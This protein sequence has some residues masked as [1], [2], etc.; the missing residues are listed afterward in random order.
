MDVTTF[1]LK[2]ETTFFITDTGKS[3]KYINFPSDDTRRIFEILN[4]VVLIGTTC[5]FGIA[6]NLINIMV[7]CKQ[8]LDNTVNISLFGIAISDLA[9]LI[10]LGWLITCLNPFAEKADLPFVPN[11]IQYLS[12]G[13]PHLCFTRTTCCIT[14]YITVERC[15]CIALP[16]KVKQIITPARTK[17]IIIF[18]FILMILSLTPEYSTTYFGWKFNQDLNRTV[19][20]LLFTANREKVAG[21]VFLLHAVFGLFSF[22][23]VTGFTVALVLKLKQKSQWRKKSMCDTS[24]SDAISTRDKK[25]VAMVVV[26]AVVLIVCFIPTVTLHTVVFFEPKFSIVGQ[27]SN[28]FH[29][30]WSFAFLFEAVNSS[31][32]IFLYY[33]MS[34]NYRQTFNELFF[35]VRNVS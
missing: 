19:L 17:C 31:V 23:I 12:G 14:L 20:G 11:E 28:I 29:V 9:S 18:I 1:V 3:E 34:S 4:H 32:N 7:F 21:F 24:Q 6:S 15:L 27:Y 33:N 35:G 8:G 30:C 22:L 26:I 10:T 13:W 5:L 25:T 16:L 2:T